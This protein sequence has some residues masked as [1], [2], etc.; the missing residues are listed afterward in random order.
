MFNKKDMDFDDDGVL[1]E[2]I[3]QPSKLVPEMTGACACI[4]DTDRNTLMSV[5]EGHLMY[6]EHL[7]QPE[8]L[9]K[10][11]YK[12]K[13]GHD[14]IWVVADSMNEAVELAYEYFEDSSQYYPVKYVE[15]SEDDVILRGLSS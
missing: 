3:E 1:R 13:C 6:Y 5:C 11:L 9:T 12:A 14:K 10:E 4:W 2:L 7:Q 15:L 8:L